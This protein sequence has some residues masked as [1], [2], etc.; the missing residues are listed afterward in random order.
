MDNLFSASPLCM[1][2]TLFCF[3]AC[4]IIFGCCGKL[5]LLDDILFV[6]VNLWVNNGIC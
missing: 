6:V 3:I 5:I 4:L 2:V 1:G